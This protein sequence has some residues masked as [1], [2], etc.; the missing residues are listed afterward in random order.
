M[1]TL[2]NSVVFFADQYNIQCIVLIW[3]SYN[4]LCMYGKT[5]TQNYAYFLQ[6]VV[7]E[8]SEYVCN[9]NLHFHTNLW[10]PTYT[11]SLQCQG[12]S[13]DFLKGFPLVK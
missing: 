2:Y 7:K 9:S 1:E 11:V 4:L 3:I 6:Q 8:L 10:L 12:H 13:Q 5:K